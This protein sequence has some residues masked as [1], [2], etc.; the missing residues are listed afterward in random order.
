MVIKKKNE[1]NLENIYLKIVICII[2]IVCWT[3]GLR[4]IIIFRLIDG[5]RGA[6]IAYICIWAFKH[7]YYTFVW[8]FLAHTRSIYIDIIIIIIIPI[9]SENKIPTVSCC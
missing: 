7:I 5:S 4:I 9:N 3:N 8:S 6:H 2:T 1:T